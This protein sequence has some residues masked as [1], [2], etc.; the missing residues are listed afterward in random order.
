MSSRE[1]STVT[2]PECGKEDE[3]I[4]WRSINT[5]LDPEM[6]EKVRTGEAFTWTCP[7]CGHTATVQYTTLYHQME[8]Q[9]MIYLVFGDQKEAIE[10][11]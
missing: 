11:M 6:K 5:M 8:D 7:H 2:C 9:V 1:F 4:T 10:I 3:F